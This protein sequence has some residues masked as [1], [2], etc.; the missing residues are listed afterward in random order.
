MRRVA[1]LAALLG[2]VACN[3][4]AYPVDVFPEMHYSQAQ[5]RLEPERLSVADGAV[6]TAGR[7]PVRS[8][9]DA[10][11]EP[12]PLP[13]AP[14]TIERGRLL[15]AQNCAMCHGLDGHARTLTAPQFAGAGRQPP[16]DLTAPRVQERTDGQLQWI[17]GNGLGGM[18]PFRD[19]LDERD[20]WTLVHS[21]RELQ[22]R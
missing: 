15:Y 20:R 11:G 12:N 5:R 7:A 2:L 6:P 21:V 10:A 19:L 4:G 8:F 17:I 18:P 1:L 13:R 3:R 9:D 16:V 14:G 22:G